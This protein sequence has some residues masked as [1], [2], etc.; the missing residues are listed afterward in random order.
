MKAYSPKDIMK[1][2]PFQLI[3]EGCMDYTGSKGMESQ[4]E[5]SSKMV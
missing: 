1:A 5:A 3:F 2:V 4:R